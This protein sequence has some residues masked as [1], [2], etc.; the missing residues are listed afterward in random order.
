VGLTFLT[1]LTADAQKFQEPTREELQMTSDPKAPGAA[2]VYLDREIRNDNQGHFISEYARIKVLS[3][4]GKEWATVEVPY[5]PAGVDGALRHLREAIAGSGG[6]PIIDAR[7]IHADGTVIPLI[8]KPEDL[9]VASS[10]GGRT[11]IVTFNLPSVEV[12]SILEY[13]WTIPLVGNGHYDSAL[14]ANAGTVSSELASSIPTWNL[15]TRLFAHRE[16]FYFNPFTNLEQSDMGNRFIYYADGEIAHYLLYTANVPQ[17]AQVAKSP[18]GDY[19]LEVKD[20][21]PIPRETNTPPESSFLYH[22]RFYYTPYYDAQLFW[23]N[24]Q[25]R[26]SKRID[27]FA[28]QADSIKAAAA[29]MTEGA[30][31]PDAKARKIYDAVQAL[32]N[33]EFSRDKSEEERQRLGLKRELKKAQDVLAEKSGTANEIAALYLAL[34]RAAGLEAYGVQVADRSRRTFDPNILSLEQL[35]ALVI[36]LRIDGKEVFLDPGQKLCP[37]GQL[38]WRHMLAGGLQQN[39]KGPIFTPPNLS[40]DGIVAHSADL[41][42]DEHGSVTGSV[43]VLMNGPEALRWRQLGFSTDAS[44]VERQFVESMK[45]LLP[46]GIEPTFDRF[47]GMGTPATNL[48]AV[49]KVSGQL[50]SPTGK[51]LL[52][53]AYFFSTGTHRQFVDEPT[54]TIPVDLHYTEQVI[55]DVIFHLP[56][57]YTVES[58]PPPTQLPWP[59]HAALVTKSTSAPGVVDIKHIYARTFVLLDAKEYPA[60]RDFYQKIATT[61][62]QQL[63]LTPAAGVSAN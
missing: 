36:D 44:E 43:K 17:G 32:D 5:R 23:S 34:V 12:G 15:Q 47:E 61:D 20:V 26:W 11:N 41:T 7:T 56:A 45:R 40:K 24:E 55:D 9:L 33:T 29:Q 42:L 31:T 60:L 49:V 57:G 28:A 2:A 27:Q 3:E 30:T 19:T 6:K 50:A 46:Q 38:H 14:D 1:V 22:V 54:R 53:P 21:P 18:K 63:V 35:D 58:T 62:Q 37:Y 8:G 52:V 25:A 59:Q 51:R 48:L 4:Q 16:Y 10:R 13:R 39:I